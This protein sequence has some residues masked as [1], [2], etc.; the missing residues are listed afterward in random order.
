M[1]LSVNRCEDASLKGLT[2]HL[3][4]DAALMDS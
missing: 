1:F 3:T 4:W 2:V